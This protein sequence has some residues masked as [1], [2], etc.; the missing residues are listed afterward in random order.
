VPIRAAG[1]ALAC[2][3]GCAAAAQ[4][5]TLDFTIY[6]ESDAVGHDVYDI[7]RNGDATTVKVHTQTDVAVLFL[8]FHYRHERTEVWKGDALQSFVS[9]TDDDGTKHHLEV[10]RDGDT[11]AATVDGKRQ[12]APGDEVPFTLWKKSL[13]RHRLFFAI[14]DFAQ[15]K[16]TVT[17]K[18]ADTVTVGAKTVDAHHFQVRGDLNW[19][20]W[21][22][23]DGLLLKTAFKRR[24]FPVFFVRE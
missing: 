12:T 23:A 4:A 15:L 5:E 11:L 21:Y 8:K 10:R 13:P 20:L 16:T 2:V 14:A 24:G 22:G 19:D 3:I 6:K 7:A 1:F 9:D 17:D 18:G